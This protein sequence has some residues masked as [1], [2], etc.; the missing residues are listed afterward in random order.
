MNQPRVITAFRCLAVLLL[1]PTSVA[2][3]QQGRQDRIAVLLPPLLEPTPESLPA[4]P[5]Q[6]PAKEAGKPSGSSPGMSY[7]AAAIGSARKALSINLATA[8][9]MTDA[10]AI[11]IALAAERVQTAAAQ[12]LR[13]RTL[14]LPTIYVG[15]D[16]YRH[17][18]TIQD[19]SGNIVDANKQSFMAG[20]GGA[21]GGQ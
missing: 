20:G 2:S 5:S 12:L 15:T 19:M 7:T 14:W 16:Y 4:A 3:A 13:A 18:G 11:D 10:R 8:L 21:A 1:V 9:S 17:D 6:Q